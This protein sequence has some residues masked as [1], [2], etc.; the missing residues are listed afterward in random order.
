MKLEKERKKR[1]QKPQADFKKNPP[2]N[3][4]KFV[5]RANMWF[6]YFWTREGGRLVQKNNWFNTQE[7]TEGFLE[8]HEKGNS[9]GG[10]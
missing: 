3:R 8:E 6:A 1:F 10:G 5:R 7:E 4:I 2:R 9:F